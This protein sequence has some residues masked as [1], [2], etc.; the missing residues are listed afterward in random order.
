MATPVHV[1]RVNNNDDE[2]RLVELKIEIG[3]Q[4][5]AGQVLAA[6]ET[7]KAVVDVESP[8]AGFVIAI[9]A[10]LGT[11]TRVGGVLL[12]LGETADEKP[13]AAAA[14][15]V[16]SDNTT[17]ESMP[18]AK[19]RSL[20]LRYGLSASQ[21]H[22]SSARLSAD[23]VERYVAER[24]LS[25]TVAKG[26]SAAAGAAPEIEGQRV[27][28]RPDER[29][30]LTT[31]TWHRDQAV[32]GYIE[33]PYDPAPWDTHAKHFGEQHGLLLN[34]MLGLMAWR[35][36]E[37]AVESP[38]LNATIAGGQRHEYNEVNLG[39]TVQAGD[40]LYL[41]VVRNAAAAG[42]LDFVKQLSGLQRRAAAH[43][44]TP[45]ETQGATI[46]FSSMARWNVS[47]HIPILAPHSAIM[48]AHA[49]S[50]D[51]QA[52]LGATYDHRVLH[53]GA[54]AALLRKLSRPRK[55]D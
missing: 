5:T 21:I 18:T 3:S 38:K 9:D 28:L 14:A 49:V 13:P 53:G 40:V 50:A 2:V 34:P 54:V 20:L 11:M 29:G 36:V 43:E 32:A 44:L 48:V 51:G 10:Q 12:W 55:A 22:A 26:P 25:P 45:L 1:P 46:G 47:R 35:L 27:A 6:V 37:L 30:M 4:V 19:A 24:G 33:L 41:A 17:G 23:D 16:P 15:R 42:E 8:A 52:V 31:V 39:F 7:D